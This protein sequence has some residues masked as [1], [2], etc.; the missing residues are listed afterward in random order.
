[1]EPDAARRAA[2]SAALARH[3]VVTEETSDTAQAMAALNRGQYAAL[4][5]AEITAQLSLRGLV[6]LARKRQPIARIVVTSLPHLGKRPLTWLGLG[7]DVLDG[8]LS[9]PVL[10][11]Q[12]V[13]ILASPNT[14]TPFDVPNTSVVWDTLERAAQGD[15]PPPSTDRVPDEPERPR[16]S[17]APVARPT[18]H[19]GGPRAH[20]VVAAPE[21]TP[22]AVAR[23]PRTP[24]PVTAP[25]PTALERPVSAARLEPVKSPSSARLAPLPAAPPSAATVLAMVPLPPPPA[26]GECTFAGD[27]SNQSSALLLTGLMAQQLTGALHVLWG[28]AAAVYYVLRGDPVWV[29]TMEGD[30][31][32]WRRLVAA[33]LIPA[34][35]IRPS[36][37]EGALLS[38][39]V[40]GG[41]IK[42]ESIRNVMF[43]MLTECVTTLLAESSGGFRFHEEDAFLQQVPLLRINTLQVM[44]DAQRRTKAPAELAAL[45]ARHG[46][47]RLASGPAL[48][49]V[50]PRI[51]AALPGR[52]VEVLLNTKLTVAQVV[53]KLGVDAATAGALLA[54][55]VETQLV[56]LRK[57]DAAAPPSPAPLPTA[58]A[59]A[60]LAGSGFEIPFTTVITDAE[61][62]LDKSQRDLQEEVVALYL[63]M[64]TLRT[65][66]AILGVP[67]HADRATA[68]AALEKWMTRLDANR[69]VG[70]TGGQQLQ[71]HLEELRYK[72]VE[73]YL[74]LT[75]A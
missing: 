16:I 3:A 7:E 62:S 8:R 61:A 13:D 30:P 35:D 36:V 41:H 20:L 53:G 32:L 42:A 51:Q 11:K 26:E 47:M 2:L 33:G 6:L 69:V 19:M 65:P 52:D 49:A 18:V 73:A 45:P 74:H 31:G 38:H 58:H 59:R 57:P 46:T 29:L 28:G 50:L 23:P 9:P 48:E 15:A 44:L 1:M 67:V 25:P 5:V 17:V 14:Q 54:T 22:S 56:T 34:Q 70:G 27:L 21:Y 40:H 63:S 66:Q 55:L 72:V 39:L 37:E 60:P 64:K 68:D 43:S 4:M 10:A 12:L 24:A 75:R 71:A